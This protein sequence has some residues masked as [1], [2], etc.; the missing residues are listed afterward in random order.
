LKLL[1]DFQR[2]ANSRARDEE[3][4]RTTLAEGLQAAERERDAAAASI[5]REFNVGRTAATTEYEQATGHARKQ[6]EEQRNA[7]QKEYKGLRHGVESEL[8]R[9]KEAARTEKQQ[10][11]WEALTV[12]DALKGRPRERFVATVKQLDRHNQELAVLEHDAVE[13][14]QMRRQWREFPAVSPSSNGELLAQSPSSSSPAAK[15]S[16][17]AVEQ[18]IQRANELVTAVRDATVSLHRQKL[19]R[20][21]DGG[22]PFAVFFA[23]W[24][25]AAIPCALLLNWQH[26][27]WVPASFG[28]AALLTATLLSWLWPIAKRQS[29]GQFQ[30]I[31]Q[32][33]AN[34]RQALR[35]TIQAAR[36]RGERETEELVAERNEQLVAVEKRV[37]ALVGER[38]SWSEEEIGRAGQTF[39]QRLAELRRA[40]DHTLET[41]KKKHA[42]ALSLVTERRDQ[43]ETEYRTRYSKRLT[44]LRAQHDRD[45]EALV[46]RWQAELNEWNESWT[47]LHAEC[48]QLFPDWNVTEYNDWPNPD[49]AVPAI[50]FGELSLDLSQIKNGISQDPRLRPANTKIRMP[51]LMTLE[52]HPV[53]LIVPVSL[54]SA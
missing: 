51:A 45:W 2:L 7:A 43:R 34:A 39:P 42:E 10:A 44:E 28:V 3:R 49:E 8:S 24:L 31:Q 21:F 48:E 6:Y 20:L 16:A 32:Q 40:L 19:P 12:F 4:I 22:T 30:S 50:E 37:H 46:E 11:S 27:I 23:L 17:E 1:R 47:R 25:I 5:G 13:I 33:L 38:E 9:V 35:S 18:A 36:D 15:G 29:T 54:R 41:A 26:W 14:M 53:L 52:E